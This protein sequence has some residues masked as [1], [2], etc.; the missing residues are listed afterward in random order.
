MRKQN[1]LGKLNVSMVCEEPRMADEFFTDSASKYIHKMIGT[2]LPPDVRASI[3]SGRA[4]QWRIGQ[5][6]VDIRFVC[7]GSPKL[8][9][10]EMKLVLTSAAQN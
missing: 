5:T 3:R 4:S 6:N 1:L 7:N 9:S 8:P 2:P 10:Y